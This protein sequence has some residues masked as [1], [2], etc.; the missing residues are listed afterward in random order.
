MTIVKNARLDVLKSVLNDLNRRKNWSCEVSRKSGC[1]FDDKP[2]VWGVNWAAIGTVSIE[3]TREFISQLNIVMLLTD[4]LNRLEIV[5]DYDTKDSRI[6]DRESF[7][8]AFNTLYPFVEYGLVDVV[9]DFL[10]EEAYN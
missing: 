8:K 4:M 3:E 1:V 9:N 7:E 10:T 6:V 2:I 5:I